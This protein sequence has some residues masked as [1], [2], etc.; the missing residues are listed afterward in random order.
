MPL[1]LAFLGADRASDMIADYPQMEDWTIGGHSMGG[2][3]AAQYVGRH[4]EEIDGL[5]LRAAHP[6]G[7]NDL[8]GYGGVV[9]SVCGIADGVA[10]EDE[11]RA[12][13][14]LLPA[15]TAWVPIEGGNHAQFGWYG[16]QRGDG[17]PT[18]SREDQQAQI[19]S[20]TARILASL[21]G[22]VD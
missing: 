12:S 5:G 7:S 21:E 1:S 10:T 9:V 4:P 17:D 2:A 6:A 20:A 22:D 13:A 11:V 15:Q 16:N 19:V 8:S 18:V 14:P 3:F